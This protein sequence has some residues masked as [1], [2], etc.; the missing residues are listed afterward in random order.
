MLN[1]KYKTTTNSIPFKHPQKIINLLKKIKKIIYLQN[2][3]F[4]TFLSFLKEYRKRPSRDTHPYYWEVFYKNKHKNTTHL[5]LVNLTLIYFT[6]YDVCTT[7]NNLYDGFYLVWREI[8]VIFIDAGKKDLLL[9]LTYLLNLVEFIVYDCI[10]P[11][12]YEIKFE[13]LDTIYIKTKNSEEDIEK[14]L[15]KKTYAYCI[16]YTALEHDAKLLKEYFYEICYLFIGYNIVEWE[17]SLEDGKNLYV[18]F[19]NNL[20]KK[21]PEFL[22]YII[23]D[24]KEIFIIFNKKFSQLFEFIKILRKSPLLYYLL[25]FR[26]NP[27]CYLSNFFN[28]SKLYLITLL[29]KFI[30]SLNKLKIQPSKPDERDELIEQL[31]YT[32]IISFRVF[33]VSIRTFFPKKKNPPTKPFFKLSVFFWAL[34]FPVFLVWE[35]TIKYIFRI[36]LDSLREL[37]VEIISIKPQIANKLDLLFDKWLIKIKEVNIKLRILL[38]IISYTLYRILA[39]ASFDYVRLVGIIEDYKRYRPP[40]SELE[41]ELY[42]FKKI[43]KSFSWK[44][45]F[46][47]TY[48][49]KNLFM[50]SLITIRFISK[51][52]LFFFQKK[53]IRPP[54][55]FIKSII[56]TILYYTIVSLFYEIVEIPAKLRLDVAVF[57]YKIRV[58]ANLSILALLKTY[59]FLKTFKSPKLVLITF[60]SL[61]ISF[62]LILF[63]VLIVLVTII[64]FR[65]LIECYSLG[66]IP[67]FY[68]GTYSSILI[69][70]DAASKLILELYPC[71]DISHQSI[72]LIRPPEAFIQFSEPSQ[73]FHENNT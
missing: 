7:L 9:T 10:I 36:I 13:V 49:S 44:L 62:K 57:K 69:S 66:F 12:M 54:L 3:L 47:V 42:F 72:N 26:I 61:A 71:V 30:R 51:N 68:K 70:E 67:S 5:I 34:L 55:F 31:I 40:K 38:K 24:T 35:I 2:T 15:L 65:F 53:F 19:K 33:K 22:D 32:L 43:C 29:N 14:K 23:L 11:D 1:K 58:S 41:P 37:F 64:Y 50:L 60:T 8:Y 16:W 52:K 4:K 46:L 73:D 45:V 6:I 63:F 25:N 59:Y 18:T 48:S 17:S 21:T 39:K 27:I 20:F 56:I 28:T